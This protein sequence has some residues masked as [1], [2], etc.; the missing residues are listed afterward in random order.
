MAGL[1]LSKAWEDTREIFARD[2][3]LLTAVALALLVLPEA[4]VGLITPPIGT[5]MTMTGRIVW[6]IA[7]L[8]GLVGQLA[9]ARLAIGPSTTVGHAIGHGGRRFLPTF[10]AL[11]L[12][13]IALAVVIIPLMILLVWSG[14]VAVP[15]EGQRPPPSFA[16]LAFAVVLGSVLLSV[17]FLLM[18]PISAAEQAGPLE[19]LKRSWSMTAGHYWR[20]FAFLVLMIVATVVLL[21]AAQA[22]GAIAGAAI[23]GRIAPFTLGALVLALF[24]SV[25]SASMTTLLAVMLARIYLQLAGHDGAQA[26]VPSSGT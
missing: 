21:L 11:V 23:A 13:G 10:G 15:I 1:S 25:A 2:G 24:Q 5:A 20:L 12:L 3:G 16:V 6:L 17:K 19:I 7:G 4:V 14:I 26:S 22:V 18:I 8:I 9:L